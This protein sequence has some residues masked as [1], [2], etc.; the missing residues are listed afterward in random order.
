M[1]EAVRLVQAAFRAANITLYVSDWRVVYRRGTKV[2]RRTRSPILDEQT[3]VRGE[4][5]EGSFV[6]GYVSS[7]VKTSIG[8]NSWWCHP[9]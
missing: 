1:R 4:R 3:A 5:K 7:L 2:P 8:L 9:W 6:T